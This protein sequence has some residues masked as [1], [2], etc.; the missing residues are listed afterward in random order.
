LPPRE[1]GD[2]LTVLACLPSEILAGIRGCDF[3]IKSL[4]R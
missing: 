3:L 4:S 1:V 2:R